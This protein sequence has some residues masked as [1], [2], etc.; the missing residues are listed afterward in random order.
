MASK[1]RFNTS[2]TNNTAQSTISIA[3]SR[4][5]G[6]SVF[7]YIFLLSPAP[8]KKAQND[9]SLWIDKHQ[10]KNEVCLLFR[11]PFLTTN[12]KSLLCTPRR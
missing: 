6:M 2:N 8:R 4:S 12:S 1:F 7:Q 11:E 5:L 10:P 3:P 9:N